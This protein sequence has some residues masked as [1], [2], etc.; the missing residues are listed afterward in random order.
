MFEEKKSN[1]NFFYVYNEKN[2][3]CVWTKTYE[4]CTYI[5]PDHEK[6]TE[7]ENVTKRGTNTHKKCGGKKKTETA[8][9]E[10]EPPAAVA[11]AE[12]ATTIYPTPTYTN[13]HGIIPSHPVSLFPF[14]S[15]SVPVCV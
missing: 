4:M 13:C 5:M 15:R 12:A 3:V 1:T 14:L 9:S 7:T 8:T 6:E 11:E 2:R 10:A